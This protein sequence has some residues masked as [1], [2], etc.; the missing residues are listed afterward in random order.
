MNRDAN[1]NLILIHLEDLDRLTDVS[2]AP[3]L[4]RMAKLSFALLATV[5]SRA[6]YQLPLTAILDRST[7]RF[8]NVSMGLD[9]IDWYENSAMEFQLYLTTELLGKSRDFPR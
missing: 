5:L 3:M 7:L 4:L 2:L 8:T 9:I 1:P 6:G